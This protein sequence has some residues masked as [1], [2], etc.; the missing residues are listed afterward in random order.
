MVGE[1]SFFVYLEKK[2][3]Y[4]RNYKELKQESNVKKD[5]KKKKKSCSQL[6]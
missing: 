3:K 6:F 2:M 1:E 4:E 5:K